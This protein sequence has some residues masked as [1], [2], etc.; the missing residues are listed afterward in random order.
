MICPTCAY[1][2][3]PNQAA[4]DA[5]IVIVCRHF[6]PLYYNQVKNTF[7]SPCYSS[8]GK[9]TFSKK[10]SYLRHT[11]YSGYLQTGT[12]ASTLVPVQYLKTL[13]PWDHK[14]GTTE[15]SLNTSTTALQQ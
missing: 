10:K 15:E 3:S 5:V 2:S 13:P 8:T 6:P 4:S 12:Y 9:N 1:L 11:G 7:W 14:A